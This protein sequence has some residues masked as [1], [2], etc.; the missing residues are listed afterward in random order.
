VQ[1]RPGD[2]SIL[3]AQAMRARE[4]LGWSAEHSDLATIITDAWR[5]H[6]I[7]FRDKT[8]QDSMAKP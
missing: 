7:R 8:R 2:P 4:L 1:R 6:R 5:W 3:V